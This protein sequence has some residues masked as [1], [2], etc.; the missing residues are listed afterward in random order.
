M[1]TKKQTGRRRKHARITAS[2][3]AK[4]AGVS[5]MTVSRVINDDASVRD[6][7]R[8]AVN[9]AIDKLGYMPNNAARSL[10]SAKHASISFLFSDPNSAYFSAVLLGV[11]EEARLAKSQITVVEC[12]NAAE[13]REEIL[14]SKRGG[15]DGI[16]VCPPLADSPHVMDVLQKSR[17][18]AVTIGPP[19]NRRDIS[20]VTIDDRAAAKTMTDHIISLGHRRIGFIKGNPR[21]AASALRLRGFRD[22]HKEAGIRTSRDLIVHGLYTYRSGLEAA[23]KL[24]DRDDPPTAIFASNDDMAVATIATAHRKGIEVPAELTVCGFDD[25][26]LATTIWP[27]LTTVRQPI[28]AMSHTAIELLE[29]NIQRR[30]AGKPS[31]S[32]H[33][34]LDYELVIRQS[35]AP[36]PAS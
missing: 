15:A 7:T 26:L 25:T 36:P 12:E 3:V 10:A 5:P 6:S 31:K 33:V 2:D 24:L 8:L 23:E 13:A 27:E 4:L 9:R 21:V 30:R 29:N 18:L 14:R 20:S 35:D 1:T 22:A 16:F 28:T 17:T 19:H 11:L 32:Q 34:N